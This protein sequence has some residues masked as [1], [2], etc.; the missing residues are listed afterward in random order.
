MCR[1]MLDLAL[2]VMSLTQLRATLIDLFNNCL[3]AF[4]F[5]LNT[6][7]MH[8]IVLLFTFNYEAAI[9]PVCLSANF[10]YH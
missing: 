3:N 4:F 5:F 7:D 6:S 9:L 10:I 8:F 2:I 1:V